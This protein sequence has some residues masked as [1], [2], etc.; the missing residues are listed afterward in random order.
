MTPRDIAVGEPALLR[1]VGEKGGKK[2]GVFF[3]YG[4][5]AFRRE[6][7]AQ[8]LVDWHLDPSTRD[9]N[10][11]AVRGSEV[12]GETLA[13]LIATPP[14]MAEW[15]VL[16]VREVEAL[17]S[18]PTLR[19]LL[20]GV[21]LEAPPDLALVLVAAI[22]AD[23]RE[24][25]AQFFRQLRERARSFAFP[26]VDPQ[27]LP[28]WLVAW[29]RERWGREMTIEAARA[30]AGIAGPETGVLAQEVVKL[31]NLVPEGELIG[32]EAV[33]KAATRIP[34]VDR[35]GWLDRVAEKDFRRALG[36]LETLLGQG[37]TA[38]G[39]VAALTTHFLRLGLALAGGIPALGEAL[40]PH[41]KF[42]AA[43]ISG[44]AKKWLPHEVEEAL[45]GLR[46]ADRLLKSGSLPPEAVL[47]EWLMAVGVWAGGRA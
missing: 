4:E 22:P 16:L 38:V 45:L 1:L 17:N 37:E 8:A 12:E 40:P 35:W 19:D 30:L 21:A 20:L 18:S 14:L 34:V 13:S 27:D 24:W 47:E 23:P 42:L 46:R 36:E 3:L 31:I 32:L 29:V 6:E 7:A 43:R 28:G 33:R 39:L 9:F 15:R 41:Q 26:A 2:G 44:Q 25:R 11:D 10:F 5:D